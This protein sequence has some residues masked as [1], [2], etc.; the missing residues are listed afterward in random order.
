MNDLFVIGIHLMRW[1]SARLYVVQSVCGRGR[2]VEN[3]NK[4]TNYRRRGLTGNPILRRQCLVVINSRKAQAA[5]AAAAAHFLKRY[6]LSL[7]ICV[8]DVQLTAH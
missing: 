3:A 1:I 2:K 6:F 4:K 8:F 7:R 5:A